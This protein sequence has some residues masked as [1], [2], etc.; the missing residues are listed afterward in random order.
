ML[1][2]FVKVVQF[3]FCNIGFID[4]IL[5]I[6]RIALYLREADKNH[7]KIKLGFIGTTS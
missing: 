1:E 5:Y 6:P 4:L 2:S 3:Y 7:S